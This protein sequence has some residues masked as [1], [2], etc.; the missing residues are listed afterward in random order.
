V[1]G[2]VGVVR[3]YPA[4]HWQPAGVAISF[5]PHASQLVVAALKAVPATQTQRSLSSAY[6]RSS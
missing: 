2:S 1:Q 6:S 5:S 3:A 4:A